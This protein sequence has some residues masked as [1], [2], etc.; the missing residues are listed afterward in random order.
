[1]KLIFSRII[2]SAAFCFCG[3]SLVACGGS[4][5][6]SAPT[7]ASA[8]QTQVASSVVLSVAA[9]SST[10]SSLTA[11]SV[12]SA[13][14]SS[15][16]SLT[17]LY[18][19]VFIDSAVSGLK[20]TTPTHSGFTNAQGEFNYRQGETITF[21]VGDIQFPSVMASARI[22][23]YTLANSTDINNL[24]VIN[25]ARFL[26][27]LDQD[28]NLDNGIAIDS[29]AHTAGIGN[30]LDFSSAQFSDLAKN[31]VTTAGAARTTLVDSI[32]AKNHLSDSLNN[33]CAADHAKVGMVANLRTIA[34]LVSGQA[35]IIDNCTIEIT[36]F[37]YDGRGLPDVFVYG[38]ID[39]NY[40]G[41]FSIGDNLFGKP[42]TNSRI[43]L[44]LKAGDLDKLNGISI[45]CVAAGVNFGDGLFNAPQ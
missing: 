15:A 42:A 13:A 33:I 2:T 5:G 22:T 27:T 41:G 39:G 16:S 28:G 40:A 31:I 37:N 17:G 32:S 1:M 35:R 44:K 20:Y 10:A 26:Q 24:S 38:G 11:T 7:V 25:I 9:P 30:S 34:H 18:T 3:V 21:S 36:Q 14:N 43:T 45:W 19:G 4:G 23:P 29:Q 8:S 6:N 12:T